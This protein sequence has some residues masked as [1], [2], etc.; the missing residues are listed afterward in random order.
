MLGSES[1]LARVE[2]FMKVPDTLNPGGD[3]TS[4]HL[5]HDFKK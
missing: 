2:E 1:M 4:P 3:H 5:S